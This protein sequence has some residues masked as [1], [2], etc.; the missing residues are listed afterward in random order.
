MP[1]LTRSA[2]LILSGLAVIAPSVPAGADHG[3]ADQASPNMIHHAQVDRGGTN[4]DLAFWNNIAAAGNY[5]GP[6]L[7]DITKPQNPVTLSTITCRGPQGDV[8]FYQAKDRLLL[9]VSVD[10]P[11]TTTGP[12]PGG[13]DCV[14]N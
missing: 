10:T 1:R 12:P 2:L 9:F 13:K 4:S 5:S 11:Q 8:S 7:L 14:S 3:N 6:R